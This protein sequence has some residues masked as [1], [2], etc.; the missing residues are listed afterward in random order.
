VTKSDIIKKV[1]QEHPEKTY[2][3]VSKETNSSYHHVAVIGR[4]MI[5]QGII[6]P[7]KQGRPFESSSIVKCKECGHPMGNIG[8]FV[9]RRKNKGRYYRYRCANCGL[10]WV[11]DQKVEE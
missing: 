11:S 7:R 5:L 8:T 2:F 3:E 1:L 10:S 9:R 6:P 4:G